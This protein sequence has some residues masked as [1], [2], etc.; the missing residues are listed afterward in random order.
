M[1]T[2]HPE[3][4]DPALIRSGRI[5]LHLKLGNCTHNQL[6]TMY[7]TLMDDEQADMDFGSVPEHVV[8]ASR[9]MISHRANSQLIPQKLKEQAEDLLKEAKPSRD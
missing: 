2:N 7:R 3:V 5:D 4:L 8:P 6:L 1:T 9:I